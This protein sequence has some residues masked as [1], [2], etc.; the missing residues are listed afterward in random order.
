M[1]S[2]LCLDPS[3]VH[4]RHKKANAWINWFGGFLSKIF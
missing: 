3:Y 2:S 4:A 1:V